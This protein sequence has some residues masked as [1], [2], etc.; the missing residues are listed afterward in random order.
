MQASISSAGGFELDTSTAA[1]HRMLHVYGRYVIPAPVADGF[2]DQGWY[3]SVLKPVAPGAGHSPH[4][5]AV[6]RAE[7][8]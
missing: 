3:Q 8:P 4:P 5:G 7:D 1:H 6:C 2:S